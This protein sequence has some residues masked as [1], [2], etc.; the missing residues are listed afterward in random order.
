MVED[1]RQ[2]AMSQIAVYLGSEEITKEPEVILH[3][4]YV[5]FTNHNALR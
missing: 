2:T 5:Q 1:V 4:I 3:M